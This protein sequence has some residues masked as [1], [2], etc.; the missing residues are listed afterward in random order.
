MPSGS[1]ANAEATR[2]LLDLVRPGSA[3]ARA[4]R[5]TTGA[6]VS[7]GDA[8]L[9]PPPRG[10]GAARA[11]RCC[12]RWQGT[13]RLRPEPGSRMTGF[14]TIWAAPHPRAGRPLLFESGGPG[15]VSDLGGGEQPTAEASA[16]S[17]SRSPSARTRNVAL[18]AR[19]P[20]DARWN[21]SDRRTP[22]ASGPRCGL[23]SLRA[24]WRC[25]WLR[26]IAR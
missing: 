24:A 16:A 22:L 9:S 14:G 3:R 8:A 18:C 7:A 26:L 6:T 2:R 19:R 12:F 5:S 13:T 4:A 23:A 15:G 17:T 20:R 1:G 10:A 25:A 11:R 21:K